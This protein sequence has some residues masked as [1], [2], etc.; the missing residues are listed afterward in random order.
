[1]FPVTAADY[2]TND[3]HGDPAR[4]MHLPEQCSQGQQWGQ[5]YTSLPNHPSKSLESTFLEHAVTTREGLQHFCAL[6]TF[7]VQIISGSRLPPGEREGSK[8]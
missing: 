7:P 3:I 8:A 1:M 2:D 6:K 5:L 4:A